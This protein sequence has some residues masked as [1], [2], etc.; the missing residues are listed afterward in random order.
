LIKILQ[1]Q[2]G[3]TDAAPSVILMTQM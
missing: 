1:Q 3:Y 2:K